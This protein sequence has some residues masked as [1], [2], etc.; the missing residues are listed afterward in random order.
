MRILI[1]PAVL[2]ALLFIACGG[3]SKSSP[4]PVA[5]PTQSPAPVPC[6]ADN[7]YAAVV[8]AGTIEDGHV[9]TLGLGNTGNGCTLDGAPQ[10]D[11]YDTAGQ[12][13]DVMPATNVICQPQAGD[14]STCVYTGKALLE[15][16]KPTPAANVNGQAIVFITVG[17]VQTFAPCNTPNVTAHSVGL[18]FSG[19]SPD[20]KVD[21]PADIEFQ[22][23]A[24]QV[25][26][27]GFGPL[28]T[29]EEPAGSAAPS[30]TTS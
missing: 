9:I 10:V 14:F 30:P 15:A 16:G 11:W 7:L 26:L 18:A 20:V 4:T 5:T 3:G 22:T 29:G 1:A 2:A 6:T 17:D 27:Q 25:T 12:K 13:L 21:L 8:S 19:I 24:T 28:A 23:C